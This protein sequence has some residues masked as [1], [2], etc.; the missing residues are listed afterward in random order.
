MKPDAHWKKPVPGYEPGVSYWKRA[1]ALIIDILL[2]NVTVAVPLSGLV[3][4][5]F[6]ATPTVLAAGVVLIALFF[7]YLVGAQH[8]TGQ[9]IGMLILRYRATRTEDLWRCVV[10][11]VFILPVFP[12]I[13]LWIIDPVFL[14]FTG[15]R[16]TERWAGSRVEVVQ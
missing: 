14:A 11:N 15:D 9:T 4:A 3:P 8:L 1:L 16:L 5:S 6:T 7:G 12:F 10:R 2:F 13:L